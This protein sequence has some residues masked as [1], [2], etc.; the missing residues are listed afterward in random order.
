M[1]QRWFSDHNSTLDF[2]VKSTSI[3]Y[4][5]STLGLWP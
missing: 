5:E 3:F 1:N 4:G 2:D